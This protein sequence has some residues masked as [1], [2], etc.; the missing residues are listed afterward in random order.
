MQGCLVLNAS[1]EPLAIVPLQRAVALVIAKKVEILAE[2]EEPLRSASDVF[3]RPSVVRLVKMVKI[4]YHARVALN[5]KNLALRDNGKCGY[6][7]G[8]GNTIDHIIP[9][10]LGGRHTWENVI[11]A[12]APCNHRKSHK[13]LEE[14]GWSTLWKPTVPRRHV[15]L[16]I[17]VADVD[18]SWVQWLEWGGAVT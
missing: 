8:K 18:E 14:L 3:P 6:C 9:R 13:T 12:C 15:H 7:G 2:G 1:Y 4:P 17:G 16:V 11:L 10:A 5:R